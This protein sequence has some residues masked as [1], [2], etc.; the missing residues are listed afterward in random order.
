[1]SVLTA[2]ELVEAG[3]SPSGCPL[4]RR[5]SYINSATALGICLP[6]HFQSLASS[7]FC[8]NLW[9]N[10][11]V[12]RTTSTRLIRLPAVYHRSNQLPIRRPDV[13]VAQ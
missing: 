5:K 2:A 7:Q 12:Y 3:F 6:A 13:Y 4:S 8:V 9:I 10:S 11:L 1:M